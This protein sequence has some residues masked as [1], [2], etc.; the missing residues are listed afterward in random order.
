MMM[1]PKYPGKSARLKSYTNKAYPIDALEAECMTVTLDV[2][3]GMLVWD[4]QMQQE[5]CSCMTRLFEWRVERVLG[6]PSADPHMK[7]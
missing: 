6:R 3:T 1:A 2:S 5:P 7:G 4:A